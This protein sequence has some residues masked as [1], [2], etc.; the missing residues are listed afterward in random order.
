MHYLNLINRR[1]IAKSM[2]GGSILMPGILQG[3]MASEAKPS[4]PLAPRAPH[5]E[6][7]AKRV[8]F[9]FLSGG[10]SHIET[11]CHCPQLYADAGK[12][13]GKGFLKAPG[14]Q[15]NPHGEC[16]MMMSELLPHLGGAADDICL[17]NSMVTDAPDHTAMTF[18]MHTGSGNVARPSMGSWV[19]YGLGSENEN[20]PSFIVLAPEIPYHGAENWG[21][22]FLPACHQG[23]RIIPGDEPIPNLR[24]R[25]PGEELQAMELDLIQKMNQRHLR[26]RENDPLLAARIRSFETAAGMQIE[27]PEVLDVERESDATLEMYG[28]KRGGAKNFAWQALAA[29][30]LAESGVRFIE[31]IDRGTGLGTNWDHHGDMKRLTKN[32]EDVDQPLA[33]L[34]QDLKQRG[35][36]EDTLLVITTEFGR[37]PMVAKPTNKGREHHSRCFSSILAGAGVKRGLVY[38]KSDEYG[39]EVAEDRVHV[40]DFHATILHLLGLD[41][42]RLTFRHAGL[43]HKLTGVNDCRVVTEVLA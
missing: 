32:C 5:F 35:M 38:G 26:G 7:K 2:V 6:P 8:I 20:L 40:H 10:V 1:A 18:M 16:G 34:I 31:V 22:E 21:A 37:T 12:K 42:Q 14:W 19:S 9:V 41:H 29:R 36:F 28:I 13:F 15:F 11:F 33:A 4:D 39:I 24:R 27:A 30:R 43:D 25:L 3:L 23:T 17:I